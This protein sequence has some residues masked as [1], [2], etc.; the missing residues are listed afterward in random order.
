MTYVAG[1]ITCLEFYGHTHLLSGSEDGSICIWG[2]S[3][4]DCLKVLRG[5]K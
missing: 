2:I 1:T 5:H 4:W 3:S